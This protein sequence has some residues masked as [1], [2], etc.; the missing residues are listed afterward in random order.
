M[1]SDRKN[2]SRDWW[3]PIRLPVPLRASNREYLRGTATA[4]VTVRQKFDKVDLKTVVVL[5]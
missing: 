1:I 4:P 5:H 2:K 3:L